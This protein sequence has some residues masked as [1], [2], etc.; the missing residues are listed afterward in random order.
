MTTQGYMLIGSYLVAG[1]SKPINAI[2]PATNEILKPTYAGGAQQLR[3]S[4]PAN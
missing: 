4:A 2:N 1:Q 3:S